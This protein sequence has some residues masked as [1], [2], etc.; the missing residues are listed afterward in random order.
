[1]SKIKEAS[2]ILERIRGKD[3]VKNNPF[4]SEE[5]AER[6]IETEKHF[7]LSLSEFEKY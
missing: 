6:F 5:A 3:Y 7:L 4:E 2:N 1:M